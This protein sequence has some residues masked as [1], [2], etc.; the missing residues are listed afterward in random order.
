VK[1]TPKLQF[2]DHI[3]FE[4]G[5]AQMKDKILLLD[6]LMQSRVFKFVYEHSPDFVAKHSNALDCIPWC[7]NDYK[8]YM[9]AAHNYLLV[10]V[11]RGDQEYILFDGISNDVLYSPI[12][13]D[14]ILKNPRVMDLVKVGALN[15][16]DVL[17][18]AGRRGDGESGDPKEG[19]MNRIQRIINTPDVYKGRE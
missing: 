9:M 4:K 3:L 6:Y 1:R 19:A 17:V 8:G 11:A 14:Y 18:M 2:Y 5:T 15:Y 10:M 7:V 12:A 16:L 13:L